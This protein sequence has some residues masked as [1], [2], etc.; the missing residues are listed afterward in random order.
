MIEV[1]N[2]FDGSVAGIAASSS[3]ATGRAEAGGRMVAD[4]NHR[5]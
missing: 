5:R 3:A 2:Q 4:D 1:C